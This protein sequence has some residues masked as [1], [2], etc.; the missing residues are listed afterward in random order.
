MTSDVRGEVKR[1]L[2][3]T[4]IV[5]GAHTTNHFLQLVLPPL[6]PLLK[7]TYDVSY[8]DLGLLMALFYV[9]SGLCQTPAGFEVAIDSGTHSLATSKRANTECRRKAECQLHAGDPGVVNTLTNLIGHKH[10]ATQSSAPVIYVI[11]VKSTS[12]QKNSFSAMDFLISNEWAVVA[13]G[14]AAGAA[15][16]AFFLLVQPVYERDARWKWTLDLAIFVMSILW[17][18]TLP[19]YL[20]AFLRRGRR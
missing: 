3:V 11:V 19:L 12:A 2:T 6:F 20:W 1:D 4:M 18:I 5:T 8:T 14:Y 13:L 16:T 15:L 7:V 17:P 9:A 10:L